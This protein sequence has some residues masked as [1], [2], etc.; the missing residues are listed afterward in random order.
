MPAAAAKIHSLAAPLEDI[1]MPTARPTSAASADAKFK[2]S[3]NGYF[4]PAFKST[5][6]SPEKIKNIKN[7]LVIQNVQIT[8]FTGLL[9]SIH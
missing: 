3:A 4:R 7:I 9:S 6:K 8:R 5:A 2:N 1:T